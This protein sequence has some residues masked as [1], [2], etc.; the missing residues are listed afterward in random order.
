MLFKGNIKL[1]MSFHRPVHKY[2]FWKYNCPERLAHL[3]GAVVQIGGWVRLNLNV[4]RII[5]STQNNGH[6]KIMD[7]P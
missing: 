7:A 1:S 3:L 6:S 4:V 5:N 2:F